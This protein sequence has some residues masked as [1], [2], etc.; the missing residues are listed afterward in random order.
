MERGILMLICGY[1]KKAEPY[2]RAYVAEE[3]HIT[4]KKHTKLME[5]GWEQ[6]LN[7]AVHDTKEAY[8]V[9][10]ESVM[11]ENGEET[12]AFQ[13]QCALC[14]WYMPCEKVIGR[15]YDADDKNRLINGYVCP[16]CTQ[17]L[18][19]IKYNG[20]MVTP[21]ERERLM[22]QENRNRKG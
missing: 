21:E 15:F 7:I 13:H 8:D 3:A 18:I 16:Q 2:Y 1:V 11:L 10:E 4:P 9:M 17:D 20:V 5:D 19:S 22:I 14:S 6:V 12:T